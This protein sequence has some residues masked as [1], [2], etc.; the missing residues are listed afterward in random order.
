MRIR[1]PRQFTT[2]VKTYQISSSTNDNSDLISRHMQLTLQ[3]LYKE[4]FKDGCADQ[5]AGI[6]TYDSQ[7]TLD[8]SVYDRYGS[9]RYNPQWEIGY[10]A[11]I[12]TCAGK[13]K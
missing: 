10:T 1:W 8:E 6:L 3:P 12:D 4:G 5:N 9:L 7:G 11:G 2:N 13:I